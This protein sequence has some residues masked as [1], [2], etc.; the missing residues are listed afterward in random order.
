MIFALLAS[1][2]GGDLPNEL[3]LQIVLMYLILIFL[4]YFIPSI[5]LYFV[6]KKAGKTAWVAFIP[7]VCYLTALEI[8]EKPKTRFAGLFFQ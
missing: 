1:S 4:Y 5:C 7:F 2:F 8:I 6:F 3:L